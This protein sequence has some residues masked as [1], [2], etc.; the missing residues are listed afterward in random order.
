M[1]AP[2]TPD[3]NRAL[4]NA[5]RLSERNAVM[6]RLDLLA[7]AWGWSLTDQASVLRIGVSQ[8]NA[9]R[10]HD[11][12]PP[13]ELIEQLRSLEHIQYGLW[14]SRPFDTYAA[15]WRR[16]WEQGSPIGATSP[17]DAVVRAADGI[18]ILICHFDS[19]LSGDFF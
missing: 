18:K 17:L 2:N 16:G 19:I 15:W 9:Y 11:A 12:E 4:Q 6:Y 14:A 5:M 3:G 13:D 10:H 1:V 8:L 7:A